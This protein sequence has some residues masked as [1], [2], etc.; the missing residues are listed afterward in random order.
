MFQSIPSVPILPGHLSFCFG[1]VKNAPRWGRAFIQKPRPTVGLKNR[2]QMPQPRTTPK[3]Y[4]P[5]NKLQIP[6]LWEIPNNM[7]KTSE[8]PYAMQIAPLPLVVI[9][10]KK[11]TSIWLISMTELQTIILIIPSLFS[12]TFKVN[13][14][15]TTDDLNM[16]FFLITMELFRQ[17]GNCRIDRTYTKFILVFKHFAKFF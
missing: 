9:I 4:F 7:I 8:A 6:Y 3:L 1:Q 10:P 13:N 12:K 14:K 5:V 15:Q 2:V 11:I 17:R 16:T